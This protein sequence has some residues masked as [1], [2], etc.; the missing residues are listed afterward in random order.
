VPAV[1]AELLTLGTG[2]EGGES[3]LGNIIVVVNFSGVLA[4]D[5][6]IYYDHF[7]NEAVFNILE[8]DFIKR[9]ASAKY[10]EHIHCNRGSRAML[11]NNVYRSVGC[12]GTK[13]R[14]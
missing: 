9:E 3:S 1:G 4:N 13:T 10:D 5:A 14:M 12:G 11:T 2:E 7:S 8:F 6:L